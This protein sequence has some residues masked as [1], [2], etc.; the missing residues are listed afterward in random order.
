MIFWGGIFVALAIL[1]VAHVFFWSWVY[2]VRPQQDELRYARTKDGW[3]IALARRAPRGQK[4]TPPVL[5]CHGLAANRGNVD[6]GI[7]RYSLSLYLAQ[8]GFDC[9]ALELR[10]HGASRRVEKDAPRRWNFDTYLLQDIPAAIEAIGA[11][12]VLWVGHSQGALL[13][14]AAAVAYPGKIAAVVAMAPPTHFHAQNELKRLLRFSFLATGRHRWLVRAVSPIA[15]LFHPSWGQF[16]LNTR[17]VDARVYR[18]LMCNVVEDISPGVLTQ[19]LKWARTDVFVSEDGKVDYR[20]GLAGA[21]QPALFVAGERDLL[22]PPASVRAGFDL[23]GGEKEYVEAKRYGHSDLIFGRD[24]P[25][26]IFPKVRNFLL[27]RS[28]A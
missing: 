11:D 10:G 14:L 22:A 13:G 24:A 20:G 3:D 17:N 4:R 28:A 21:K 8:S 26:E 27:K 6:F 9:Y 7:D 23:W 1:A 5:L 12:K 16:A 25:E 2:R 15:G 19:F 18:Q